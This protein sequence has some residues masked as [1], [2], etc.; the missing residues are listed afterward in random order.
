MDQN[1]P[2]HVIARGTIEIAPD[3][4]EVDAAMDRIEK[5]LDEFEKRAKRMFEGL[6]AQLEQ[7]GKLI[8][9]MGAQLAKA[10][11]PFVDALHNG[12][13]TA[14]RLAQTVQIPTPS[15]PAANAD[16]LANPAG[17]LKDA[18]FDLDISRIA[19]SVESI[20]GQVSQLI[21]QQDQ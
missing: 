21:A 4:R 5:R 20:E 13:V 7:A 18:R 15:A 9:D 6:P 14:Q 1:A 16:P 2:S 10:A 3:S 19:N 8:D 17:Q 11:T 12:I